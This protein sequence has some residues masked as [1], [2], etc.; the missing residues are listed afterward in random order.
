MRERFRGCKKLPRRLKKSLLKHAAG[1]RGFGEKEWHRLDTW[2]NGPRGLAD[3]DIHDK[4]WGFLHR[5][6]EAAY[7][8]GRWD[9]RLFD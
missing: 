3:T 6:C 1:R 9:F 8:K 5:C 4:L 2:L 7:E